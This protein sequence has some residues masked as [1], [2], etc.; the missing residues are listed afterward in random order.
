MKYLII[1]GII[2]GIILLMVE[3]PSTMLSPGRLTNGHAQL[4]NNCTG[5]H[6]PFGGISNNK[7]IACHNLAEIGKDTSENALTVS[8]KKKI[9]FH[10][11]LSSQSCIACHT[12]HKGVDAAGQLNGFKHA[13]LSDPL[14]N[15]CVSCHAMPTDNLHR[16]VNA[17]CINCHNTE[18]WKNVVKFNH[19]ML[20]ATDKTDC[21]SCHQ[22]P[23]DN[24]HKTLLD[25]CNTCH[26][27]EKWV[28]ANFNHASYFVLDGDHN[29]SCST[30]H[31]NNNY[32]TYTC[33]GCHEHTTNNILAEHN[34]EGIYNINN[35]VEC[36][37]SG[38]E[39]EG[40]SN[41]AP[42]GQKKARHNEQDDD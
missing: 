12:D 7:C 1:I 10:E 21:A 36:H 23:E 28:P 11:G 38:N 13:L 39:T 40:E 37:K 9:L 30:C 16:Q 5:C 34:E 26:S 8:G 6:E 31:K 17:S 22:K 42:N 14:L 33:Y 35:C 24:F 20:L 27:T 3:F 25:N 18:A 4:K 15:N 2:A 32:N 29:V 19:S 41:S